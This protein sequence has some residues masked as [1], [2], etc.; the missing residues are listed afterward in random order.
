M[1]SIISW[2]AFFQVSD[3]LNGLNWNSSAPVG[4]GSIKQTLNRKLV[5]L[6]EQLLEINGEAN[7]HIYE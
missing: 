6:F 2:C 4:N 7:D 3:W 5:E 1:Y